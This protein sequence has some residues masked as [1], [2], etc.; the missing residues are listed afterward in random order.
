MELLQKLATKAWAINLYTK[1]LQRDSKAKENAPQVLKDEMKST[2]PKGS[3]AYSTTARRQEEAMITF[4][5]DK[6]ETFGHKFGLPELPIQ[7]T[8]NMKHRYDPLVTQVTNLLMQHGKL[9]VAQTVR[10]QFLRQ[11]HALSS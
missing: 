8:S 9:S 5:D 7:S 3:R 6:I 4:E 11:T 2:A 1:V 10:R